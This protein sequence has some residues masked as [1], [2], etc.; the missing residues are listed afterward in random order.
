M[1][2]S[3]LILVHNAE[4]FIEK[5]VRSLFKQSYPHIEYVLIDDASSDRSMEII[6][7]VLRDFP[8]RSN[9]IKI[10]TNPHNLGIAE[11][12]N[13]AL[14]NASGEFVL[15]VDSDDRLE[16]QAVEKLVAKAL[17]HNA[18]MVVYDSYAEYEGTEKIRGEYFPDDKEGYI[19]ALLYRQVRAAMW[20]KM[21]RR[22]VFTSN[23]LRFVPGMNY[24]ED[25]YLSPILAY[26]A[27]KIVKL[28]EPLYHYRRH[29]AS[30]SY[31]LSQAKAENVVSAANLLSLFF[32]GVPDA[33]RYRPMMK[34]MFIRN[35]I[36]ILQAGGREAWEYAS[37][38]Y[39]G[40]DYSGFGLTASQRLLLWLHGRKMWFAM[41][42]Y[43]KIAKLL[44]RN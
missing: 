29:P 35:K 27:R 19:R 6:K 31:E 12:R 36:A 13:I 18:D 3:I 21:I 25:Y 8:N 4:R 39:E 2:I 30:I 9:D 28:A 38:L 44:K 26:H 17:S 40:I 14:D 43:R 24:G 16:L 33:E 7:Q 34:Q 42:I 11:S 22:D 1:K 5:C 37:G 20:L 10:I 41:G 32:E 15:Y 23:N